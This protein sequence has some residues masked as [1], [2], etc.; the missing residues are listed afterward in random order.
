MRL[1]ILWGIDPNPNQYPNQ[2]EKVT[3]ICPAA[4]KSVE[5]QQEIN[6]H[7]EKGRGGSL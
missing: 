7:G 2:R 3:R 4:L 5:G 1:L 6:Q